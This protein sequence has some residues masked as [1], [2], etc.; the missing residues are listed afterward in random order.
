[1]KD[2]ILYY[3][4]RFLSLFITLALAAFVILSHGLSYATLIESGIWVALLFFSILAWR[5]ETIGQAAFMVFGILYLI[6][7]WDLF[8]ALTLT[9]I[10]GPLFL[11]SL[12]YFFSKKKSKM[13]QKKKPKI[14][15][16]TPENSK[17]DN[18]LI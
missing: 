8:P 18:G 15:T 17:D 7:G 3:L 6:L 13:F 5:G 11:V 9:I 1:M 2:K 12:L 10:A 14:S 16:P 4:P